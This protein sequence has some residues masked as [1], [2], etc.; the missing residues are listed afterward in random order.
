MLYH[1][2]PSV[3]KGEPFFS[4]RQAALQRRSLGVEAQGLT[5]EAA[6]TCL[7]HFPLWHVGCCGFLMAHQPALV[8]GCVLCGDSSYSLLRP[9]SHSRPGGS[10]AAT[11]AS[12]GWDYKEGK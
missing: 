5:R 11:E 10:D 1:R 12:P 2:I 8:S 4:A 9:N 7:T 6:D 3:I